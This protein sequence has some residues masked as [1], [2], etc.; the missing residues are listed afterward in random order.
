MNKTT[1]FLYNAKDNIAKE[2]F[3]VAVYRRIRDLREDM[4]LKQWQIAQM[5]HIHLNT[6][7]M[8]ELGIRSLPLDLAIRLAQFYKVSLDY[9]VGL[10]NEAGGRR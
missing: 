9:L 10:T 4:D 7:S 8:Y 3:S 5:L 6:Y 1:S 2:G